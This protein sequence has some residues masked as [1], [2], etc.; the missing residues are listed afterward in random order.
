LISGLI[1]GISINITPSNSEKLKLHTA[2]EVTQKLWS[3][4]NIKIKEN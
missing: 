1:F 4:D 3:D 2:N